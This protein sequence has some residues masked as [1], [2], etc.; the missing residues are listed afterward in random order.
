MPFIILAAAKAHLNVIG[1]D[2]DVT[3]TQKASSA[4]QIAIAYLNRNVYADQTAMDAAL[5]LVP[6]ALIAAGV[7]YA[8]ADAAADLITDIDARAAD[9][10]YAFA[11]YEKAHLAARATR[12]GIVINDL[13]LTGMLL[14]LGDLY[15][16]RADTVI[17]VSV[18]AMPNGARSIL[19]M[20]RMSPGI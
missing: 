6:A 16:E 11:Q 3:I 13:I 17:G 5:A 2:D 10:A 19:N 20:H 15:A 9:K 7:D 8:A 18:N 12:N 1:A 4:E 14:I